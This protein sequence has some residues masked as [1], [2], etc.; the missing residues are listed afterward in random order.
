[1]ARIAAI[2]A[3]FDWFEGQSIIMVVG[4]WLFRHL[5]EEGKSH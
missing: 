3:I 4:V 1:M 2:R 5:S